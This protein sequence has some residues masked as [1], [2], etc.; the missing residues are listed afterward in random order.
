[1]AGA[2]TKSGDQRRGWPWLASYRLTQAM[3]GS[4]RAGKDP[5]PP[6]STPPCSIPPSPR[7]GRPRPATVTFRGSSPRLPLS[8][9][10]PNRLPTPHR[11]GPHPAVHTPT[12]PR[13]AP[14]RCCSRFLA[15]MG[16]RQLR[17]G[18][19]T[20]TDL[21]RAVWLSGTG[22]TMAGSGW[23]QSGGGDHGGEATAA[24]RVRLGDLA[25]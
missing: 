10:T 1:M 5:T 18:G 17:W 3:P 16:R 7:R 14:P 12:P 13:S 6:W 19:A 20:K 25:T 23:V 4:G 22:P 11:G 24:W 21:G 9:L 15:A 8:T 2:A